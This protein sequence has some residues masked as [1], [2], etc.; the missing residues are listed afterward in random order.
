MGAVSVS[1]SAT[2]FA[3]PNRLCSQRGGA[4]SDTRSATLDGVGD[5][6]VVGSKGDR[7]SLITLARAPVFS[8]S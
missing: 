3:T 8:P 6:D 4:F 7:K 2:R 5:G 1:G